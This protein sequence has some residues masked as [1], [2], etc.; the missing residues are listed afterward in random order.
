MRFV[1]KL[2]NKYAVKGEKNREIIV[3]KG[4]WNVESKV[5]VGWQ[6]D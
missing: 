6:F 2:T 4:Y 3:E 5:G 1:I